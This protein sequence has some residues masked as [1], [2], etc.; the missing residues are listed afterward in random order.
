[1]L[2][3]VRTTKGGGSATNNEIDKAIQNWLKSAPDREGGSQYQRH[4]KIKTC[5]VHE[6]DREHQPEPNADG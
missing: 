3:T 4:K 2:S 5:N 1:M 6:S